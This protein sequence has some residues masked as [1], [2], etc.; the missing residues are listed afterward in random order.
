MKDGI[1]IKMKKKI[2]SHR[3]RIWFLCQ[4]RDYSLPICLDR[5]TCGWFFSVDFYFESYFPFAV[6]FTIF[7]VLATHVFCKMAAS[8]HRVF[9]HKRTV[10]LIIIENDMQIDSLQVI[11]SLPDFQ[12]DITGVVPLF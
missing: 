2:C 5:F 3:S 7:C 12:A 1:E 8:P 10:R 4:K 9:A 11:A 6:F